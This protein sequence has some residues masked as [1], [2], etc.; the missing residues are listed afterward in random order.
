MFLT[1]VRSLKILGAFSHIFVII[2][3]SQNKSGTITVCID[4]TYFRILLFK[5]RFTILTM[6]FVDPLW[7]FVLDDYY[8]EEGNLRGRSKK[9]ADAKSPSGNRG[10]MANLT[11]SKNSKRV[12][13][14]DDEEDGFWDVITGAPPVATKPKR[15]SKSFSGRG[16]SL[17]SK[18]STTQS[19]RSS[20]L[21]RSQSNLSEPEMS[22]ND[23]KKNG[24]KQRFPWNQNS[25][26]EEDAS[27]MEY[28][29]Q[30]LDVKHTSLSNDRE[31]AESDTF[32]PMDLL[33]H[34]ADSLDP[35]G[36]EPSEGSTS[37]VDSNDGSVTVDDDEGDGSSY[38]PSQY[39]DESIV[40]VGFPDSSESQMSEVK[41]SK[42]MSRSST[43][44]RNKKSSSKLGSLMDQQQPNPTTFDANRYPYHSKESR[45]EENGDTTEIR[46]RVNPGGNRLSE[47]VYRTSKNTHENS[48]Q[49]VRKS[50][51]WNEKRYPR[52]RQSFDSDAL[53]SRQMLERASKQPDIAAEDE[54]TTSTA[55]T[56]KP[57]FDEIMGPTNLGSESGNSRRDDDGEEFKIAKPPKVLKK[58][59]CGLNKSCVSDSSDRLRRLPSSR[60]IVDGKMHSGFSPESDPM[61]GMLGASSSPL[62][63]S[64]R[65]QSVF[66]YDYDSNIN[67][68]VIY[69]KPNHI[70]RTGISVRKLGI[71]PPISSLLGADDIVIQVE[72]RNDQNVSFKTLFIS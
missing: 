68:D 13:Y 25:K 4:V 61:N 69:T 7:E 24:F 34:I 48:E 66:E 57:T 39:A 52:Y 20:S 58:V 43:H 9:R 6:S 65:P 27:M 47:E 33:L 44:T 63:K 12:E 30:N 71:P 17:L 35:W 1:P 18:K 54:R 67:M 62:T 40:S 59:L 72:V 19:T 70:P 15:R 11:G 10:F 21:T 5:Q 64:K 3:L 46:L 29:V 38:I 42:S 14:R 36:V 28:S 41:S 23:K 50:P 51:T 2:F 16:R 56:S 22:N 55:E 60:V 32:D 37:D 26:S 49:V 53:Q 8:E 31:D 45:K